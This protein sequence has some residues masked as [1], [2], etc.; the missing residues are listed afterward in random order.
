MGQTISHYI[1]VATLRSNGLGVY[2][3]EDTRFGGAT[4]VGANNLENDET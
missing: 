3:G 4:V 1:V 2:K